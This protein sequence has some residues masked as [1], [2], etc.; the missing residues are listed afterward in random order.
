MLEEGVVKAKEEANAIEAA[1]AIFNIMIL[2]LKA[3]LF[4]RLFGI[5]MGD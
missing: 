1:S 4:V 5:V 3:I 2:E